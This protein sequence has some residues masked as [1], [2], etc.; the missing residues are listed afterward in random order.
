MSTTRS[1]SCMCGAIRFEARGEPDLVAACHCLSCRKHSGAPV[2]VFADYR[3]DHVDF[4]GDGMNLYQSSPGVYRGFCAHCGSTLTYQADNASQTVCIHIGALEPGC[5]LVP[6]RNDNS[7]DRID[8]V[9]IELPG[10]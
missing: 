4:H 9:H 3:R 1:G 2:A 7:Q 6:V 5:D 10:S 8:W